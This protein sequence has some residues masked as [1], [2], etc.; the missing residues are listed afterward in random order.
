MSYEAELRDRMDRE[1]RKCHGTGEARDYFTTTVEAAAAYEDH[2]GG[3][4]YPKCGRCGGTGEDPDPG[5][6]EG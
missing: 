6:P 3:P 1:C 5:N 4:P 2:F